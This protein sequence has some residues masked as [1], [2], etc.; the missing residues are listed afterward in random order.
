MNSP[1]D[2]NVVSFSARLVLASP[3]P[4][5]QSGAPGVALPNRGSRGLRASLMNLHEK[6]LTRAG[7]GAREKGRGALCRAV[8]ISNSSSLGRH[9]AGRISGFAPRSSAET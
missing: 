6:H 4:P 1:F 2:E 9:R 7:G 3:A 8:N 5:G